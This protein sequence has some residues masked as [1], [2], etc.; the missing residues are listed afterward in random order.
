[1]SI[2][3]ILIVLALALA[4]LDLVPHRL[5][6]PTLTLSVILMAVVLLLFVVK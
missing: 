4:L 3:L 5:G 2:A 6:V 1:M